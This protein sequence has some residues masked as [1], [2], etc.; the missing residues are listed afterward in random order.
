MGPARDHQ[1]STALTDRTVTPQI[2]HQEHRDGDQY[3]EAANYNSPR[4]FGCRRVGYHVR[5]RRLWATQLPNVPGSGIAVGGG[6]VAG[7]G[8]SQRRRR[9]DRAARTGYAFYDRNGHGG[10][11]CTWCHAVAR[12][13]AQRGDVGRDLRIL[14]LCGH[15]LC[16]RTPIR[17]TSLTAFRGRCTRNNESPAGPIPPDPTQASLAVFS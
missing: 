2:P 5:V 8:R 10:G 9:N 17:S 13:E 6:G 12:V 14:P 16:G 7:E 11:V 3:D 15:D 1:P 4:R